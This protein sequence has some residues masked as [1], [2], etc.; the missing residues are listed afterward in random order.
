MI[1]WTVLVQFPIDCVALYN[2][3]F[4]GALFAGLFRYQYVT[5]KLANAILALAE[6]M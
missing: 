2:V 4:N 3:D 1:L 6:K 5:Q